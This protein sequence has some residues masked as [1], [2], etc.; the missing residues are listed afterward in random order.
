[1]TTEM[2]LACNLLGCGEYDINY[3]FDRLTDNEELWDALDELKRENIEITAGSLWSEAM[4]LSIIKIFGDDYYDDFELL[5]NFIDSHV[6]LV[7]NERL[8]QMDFKEKME[9]FEEY[10]GFEIEY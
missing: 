10:T 3:L 7:N 8:N 1:M 9:E 4:S 6:T 5:F 2:I